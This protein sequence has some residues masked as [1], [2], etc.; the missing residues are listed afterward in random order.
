MAIEDQAF[1]QWLFPDWKVYVR[2][3]TDQIMWSH[4]LTKALRKL[5]RCPS[6]LESVRGRFTAPSLVNQRQ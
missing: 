5:R 1:E 6:A 2:P 4:V 3:K